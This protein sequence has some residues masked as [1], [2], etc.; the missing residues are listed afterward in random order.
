MSSSEAAEG[1]RAYAVA[2]PLE[3]PRNLGLAEEPATLDLVGGELSAGGKPVD[4]LGLA[5]EDSREFVD[6]E[7]GRQ[8]SVAHRRTISDA[9]DG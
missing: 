3:P 4:L 5:A 1:G 6:G 2:P 7:K 9:Q 8:D